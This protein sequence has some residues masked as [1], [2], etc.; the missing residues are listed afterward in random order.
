ME[1]IFTPVNEEKKDNLT[2]GEALLL[3]TQG[4]VMRRKGWEGIGNKVLTLS[5]FESEDW[6]V[7]RKE[8]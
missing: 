4:Y 5:D 2:F 1:Q 7:Y 3:H 6:F 8:S